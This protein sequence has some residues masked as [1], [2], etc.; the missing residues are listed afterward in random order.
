MKAQV[1]SLEGSVTGDLELPEVFGEAYRPDLIKRTVLALQSTRYQPHGSHPYAGIRTSAHSW[2]SGR[3]VSHVPRLKNGSRAAR[4]PQA[5]GGREAHPPKVL[6]VLLEKVNKKEKRKALRSAI[7]ATADE[8][9]VRARG[10][11]F[12]CILPV[13]V[14]D[15]LE[16]LR[17]TEEVA[18]ALQTLGIYPDVERSKQSRNVRPGR[19]KLRGRRFKQRKSVLI[20]TAAEPLRAAMNLP[21]VDAVSV[22]SLNTELLAPG[23]QAGRLTI[24]TEG[25]MKHLEGMQ[26]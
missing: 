8:S 12:D 20:V 4:V 1:K 19:G 17:K 2:G 23:T 16:G 22:T 25:A 14:E 7:A 26:E 3:G 9:L 15:R 24:W 10:H 18:A 6:K 11:R 5:K 13:V 21:G